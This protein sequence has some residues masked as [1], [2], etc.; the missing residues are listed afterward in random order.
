MNLS[1][2]YDNK[3]TCCREFWLDGELLAFIQND[4]TE[5]WADSLGL[6]EMWKGPWGEY[7]DVPIRYVPKQ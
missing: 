3:Q 5:A 6:S 4:C 2:M 1:G 7:P